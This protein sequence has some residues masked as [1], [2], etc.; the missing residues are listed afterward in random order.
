MA[1]VAA[2]DSP[3]DPV[4]V[5]RTHVVVMNL[6]ARDWTGVRLRV[7]RYYEVELPRLSAGGRLDVPLSRLQGGFGRYFDV[8]RERVDT[9]EVSGSD[10]TGAPVA[11]TW[12]APP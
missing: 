1:A 11:L 2:C 6:T 10:V 5:T 7:N 12:R 8:S 9:V 3:V 4:E